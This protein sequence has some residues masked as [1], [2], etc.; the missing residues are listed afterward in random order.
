MIV[1][2]VIVLVAILTVLP[3][4]LNH[5]LI[6]GVDAIFHFNRFYDVAQQ[7]AHHNYSYFQSN[8]GFQQTGRI[9]NALYGPYLAYALGWILLHAGTW[10]HFE[11]IVGF[12]IEVIAGAGAYVLARTA[13]SR[14]RFALVA[15][16]IFMLTGWVPSWITTQEFMGFGAAF[17]PFVLACGVYMVR[18]P[19]RR[20]PIF[21]L[22]ISAALLVQTHALSSVIVAVAMVPFVVM[23]FV[24][25]SRKGRFVLGILA[26][27]VLVL[28]LTANVW[29]AMLEVFGSN[30]VLAPYMPLNSGT[31]TSKLSLGNYGRGTLGG[32]L[33]IVCTVFFLGQILALLFRR[34]RH[35]LDVVLT[36]TGVFFLVA[37][38]SLV[39]WN[40]IVAEHNIVGSYLQ[41]P[42]RF[43]PV[44]TLLLMTGLARTLSTATLHLSHNGRQVLAGILA[45]G[46]IMAGYQ[47]LSDV[48][49]AADAWNKPKLLQS[50]SSVT[51][52]APDMTT[53]REAF[54]GTDLGLPLQMVTKATPDYLPV[55]K[56]SVNWLHEN[57][58]YTLYHNQTV[59][60]TTPETAQK[61][62]IGNKIDANAYTEQAQLINDAS[63]Y[64]IYYDQIVAKTADFTKHA[65][66]NGRLVVEWQAKKRGVIQVPAVSYAHTKLVL[67][68]HV[69]TASDYQRTDIGALIVQQK[70]GHNRLTLQY[71]PAKSTTRILAATPWFWLMALAAWLLTTWLQFRAKKR[72]KLDK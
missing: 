55:P 1:A 28:V 48:G 70:K 59:L 32:S 19:Q 45:F 54:T 64:V 67:N 33:G 5:S 56:E 46:V 21:V 22:A 66:R 72:I 30:H 16:M 34:K 53:I 60:V 2:G 61:G 7:I 25:S 18:H 8:Y 50:T 38:S 31:Y 26:S 69:L 40:A 71:V 27:L 57:S 62:Q 58:Q 36:A 47:T 6:V 49:S 4:Y 44:A 41:F 23:A 10:I 20:V 65:G 15:S 52:Q 17:M 39:P 11:L 68:G 24:R 43:A 42:S 37:A 51:L 63:P 35:T 13:G 9:V 12:L 29:G 3:Q 14:Q